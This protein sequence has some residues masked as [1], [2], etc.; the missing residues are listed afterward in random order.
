MKM[1]FSRTSATNCAHL[2][3]LSPLNGPLNNIESPP[4]WPFSFTVTTEQV[5]DGFVLLVLLDDHQQQS[6][7]LEKPHTSAQKDHFTAALHVCNLRFHL[8]ESHHYCKKCLC[9]FD[10]R[11]VWV[12]VMDGVTIG[13]P[14]C[15]VYNCKVPLE[16]NQH[17]CLQ[18]AAQNQICT[19]VGCIS[20]TVG[21]QP[22]VFWLWS[23]GGWENTSRG[24]NAYSMPVLL[25]PMNPSMLLPLSPHE[26]L[27]MVIVGGAAVVVLVVI[28]DLPQSS[29]LPVSMVHSMSSQ[30]LGVLLWWLWWQSL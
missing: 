22:C 23:P 24:F 13:C 20:L 29:L 12:V 10:S 15:A 7:V 3:N 5:W 14:C 30:C 11:K 27:P 21:G 26:Q 18:D 4:D 9:M 19:I 25:I 28:V 1:I 17:F 2:Y 16:N 8:H 6:K